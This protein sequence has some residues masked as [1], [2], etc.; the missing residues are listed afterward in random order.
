MFSGFIFKDI[1][2]RNDKL[3]NYDYLYHE[4][5]KIYSKSKEY[6][7]LQIENYIDSFDN[8][9]LN[10]NSICEDWFP[11]VDADIF[12][13]HSH[14]DAE[15][16]IYL[17]GWF[18]FNLNLNCF[19]DSCVWGYANDLLKLFDDKYCLDKNNNSYDYQLR[20]LTTTHTHILL[21]SSLTKM[22]D[23]TEILLF[24]DSPNSLNF[25]EAI[26]TNSTYSPW[27]YYE[28]LISKLIE[29]RTKL[30]FYDNSSP[31]KGYKNTNLLINYE[32]E[33]NHLMPINIQLLL[34]IVNSGKRGLDAINELYKYYGIKF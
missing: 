30:P 3:S 20:N 8:K 16:A 12:I 28:L 11:I 31:N 22:I 24:L 21:N 10:A 2:D 25:N 13:S 33:L 29:K 18:K 1:P 9:S 15:F 14:K 26:N 19:I 4:G 5:K 7:K 6:I 34:K 32:P 23:K 17:A 27:I